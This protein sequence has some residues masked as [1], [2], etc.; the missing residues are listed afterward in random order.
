MF[1]IKHQVRQGRYKHYCSYPLH[2]L[3]ETATGTTADLPYLVRLT[4][5]LSNYACSALR[6]ALSAA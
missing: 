2:V 5:A 4:I 6:F 1:Y 3:K